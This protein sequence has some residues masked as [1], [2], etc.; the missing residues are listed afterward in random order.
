MIASGLEVAVVI[1]LFLPTMD[2]EFGA[3]HVKTTR[4]GESMPSAL[5]SNSRLSAAS[6][7]RFSSCVRSS[8][9]ND[10]KREVKA[11]PCSQI[12]REPISRKVGS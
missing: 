12:F 6:P 10:C 1:T 4:R 8:V 9:L 3:V 7:A 2:P 5:A 11:A